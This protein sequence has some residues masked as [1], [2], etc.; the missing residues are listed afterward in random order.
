M[1][2]F[3]LN[4]SGGY[5]HLTVYPP[6]AGD[7]PLYA[8]DIMNRMKVLAIP[9]V[10]EKFIQTILDEAAGEPVRLVPWPEGKDLS[11]RCEVSLS[12][13][14]MEAY[15]EVKPPK[16]GGE[17]ITM[18][19]IVRALE[20][21]NITAGVE[22]DGLDALVRRKDYNKR[23]TAARGKP[24]QDG[25][26]ARVKYHFETRHVPYR[27]LI[28]GRIDLKELNYIQNRRE[29]D[30]LAELLPAE[31]PRDGYTV[32]GGILPAQPAGK[33][34]ELRGGAGTRLDENRLYA[35]EDGNARLEEGAV[36]VEPVVTLKNVDYETGNIAFDGSVIIK[37]TVA[38]GFKVIAGGD[39]EAEK[40]IGR[41]ELAAG[42]SILLKQGV[43]GDGEADLTA[44]ENLVSK[45]VESSRISCGGDLIVKEAVMNSAVLVKGNVLLSGGRAELLGGTA[46]I[47]GSLWCRKL[48]GL[49]EPPT[50]VIIGL[51]P[52][53][54]ESYRGLLTSIE[55]KRARLDELDRKVGLIKHNAESGQPG[56]P[57]EKLVLAQTQLEGEIGRLNDEIQ[58]AVKK[59]HG[60]RRDAKIRKESIL[61]AQ[62]RI[63]GG[64][65]IAFGF[66]D[67]TGNSGGKGVPSTV[68]R[69]GE[70][71]ITDKG[72]NPQEPPE[73]TA[74]EQEET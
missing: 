71:R 65:H 30:L 26:A 18:A 67:Y 53:E 45:Y 51:D 57:R 28:Y 29:G 60:L 8:D 54:L 48:G 68:L 2:G 19:L 22:R 6:Q 39:I 56:V 66:T 73:L 16:V 40:C 36:I 41:V 62:D 49:Y 33:G 3:V 20:E 42:R 27:E 61:V 14:E 44:G 64:V 74:V 1:K 46:V 37:G 11:A 69:L 24:P 52:D 38:D 4:Y 9:P 50:S 7:K 25:R 59:S 5:A 55:S 70:G 15:L 12:E 31:E 34:E 23:I 21:R 10:R 47:R 63:Y 43:N 17:E 13:D 35:T 72:F 58:V 32:T